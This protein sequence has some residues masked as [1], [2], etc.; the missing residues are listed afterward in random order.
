MSF[1][2]FIIIGLIAGWL[3]AKIMK[4]SGGL[5]TNLIVGAVGAVLGGALFDLLDIATTSLLGNLVMATIGAV[6]LIFLLQKFGAK[7]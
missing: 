1:I 7:K 6:L 2:Y 3:A 4:T 5:L